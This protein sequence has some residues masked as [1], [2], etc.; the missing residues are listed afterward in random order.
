[1][2]KL[3]ILALVAILCCMTSCEKKDGAD[4]FNSKKIVTIMNEMIGLSADE[5]SDKIRSYGFKEV[6]GEKVVSGIGEIIYDYGLISLDS[7]NNYLFF[8]ANKNNVVYHM[9]YGSYFSSDKKEA[10]KMLLAWVNQLGTSYKSRVNHLYS[11]DYGYSEY[12]EEYT[13]N[14]DS[15]SVALAN[16]PHGLYRIEYSGKYGEI[17]MGEFEFF[18]DKS[19]YISKPWNLVISGV[20]HNENPYGQ[21]IDSYYIDM[22]ND[23]LR[24]M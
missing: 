21:V 22:W 12:K 16:H 1:M 17:I 19:V 23:S 7:K 10:D 4:S 15:L 2:K 11:F 5:V 8:A 6:Y 3:T 24:Y 20:M 13:Y 18:E 9:T 14:I